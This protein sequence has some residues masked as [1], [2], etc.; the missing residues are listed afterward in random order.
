MRLENSKT[1]VGLRKLAIIIIILFWIAILSYI[2]VFIIERKLIYPI[3]NQSAVYKY[4]DEYDIQPSII[5]SIIKIE[6]GFDECAVSS[7]NA[8]GLMQITDNTAKYIA[9]KLNQ[10]NYNLFSPDTNIKFGVYYIRYLTDKFADLATVITAYNAGEGNVTNWLENKD[11]SDDG[12]RLKV[13]PFRE[14]RE[15]L[16]KFYR[17][18]EKY[19]KLYGNILDKPK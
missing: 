18:L 15:Y 1:L 2:G 9:N 7:K 3:K 5:F 11:Y 4:C 6:S 17:T 10:V 12:I 8:K 16:K 13:I 14:T 19:R